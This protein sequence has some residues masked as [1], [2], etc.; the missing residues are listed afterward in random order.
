MCTSGKKFFYCEYFHTFSFFDLSDSRLLT[1]SSTS[2][3]GIPGTAAGTAGHSSLFL[4]FFIFTQMVCN[5]F[6][7]KSVYFW[8]PIFNL[9][10]DCRRLNLDTVSQ[11]LN[12]R[13]ESKIQ[14]ICTEIA[15][16][17][18]FFGHIIL[19]NVLRGVHADMMKFT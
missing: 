6:S 8:C 16:F 17:R 15:K 7:K 13:F 10:I 4:P 2:R 11:P 19:K 3:G 9:L 12:Y 14:Q 5:N 18:T 1:I